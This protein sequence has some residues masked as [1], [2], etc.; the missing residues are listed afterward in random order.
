MPNSVQ[1][2]YIGCFVFIGSLFCE[3]I[4]KDDKF[5]T[6][7]INEIPLTDIA[8]S[9][10]V[11]CIGIFGFICII[12]SLTMIPPSTVATLRTSQIFVA[13]IAQVICYALTYRKNNNL[14]KCA[15]MGL[16]GFYIE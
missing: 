5:F 2:F 8:T 11:G 15:G 13:F 1:L 4:D 14:E 3:F 12:K 6:P 16:I 7:Y 9:F 10:G